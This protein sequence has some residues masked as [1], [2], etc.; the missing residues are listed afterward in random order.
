MKIL[1]ANPPCILPL[2]EG[3]ELSFVRAGSRWPFSDKKER[4]KPLN[5]IPFPF[6]L[7][8]LAALLQKDGHDVQV[9]DAVAL[10]ED[11]G[12]FLT[13]I[14]GLDPD[15]L[16]FET[17]TPT[18]DYDLELTRK[19]RGISRARIALAGAHA[20]TFAEEILAASAQIDFVFRNEYEISF[21]SMIS[22][23][24]EGRGLED[25]K[26][27]SLR[28]GDGSAF[29]LP[30]AEPVNL[31]ELDPPARELFPCND[32]PNLSIYWDGFCQFRPA[33]QMH[34]SRGCP[35]RCNFCVWN[36]VMY[37]EGRY[38]MFDAARVVDEM[39][40]MAGKYGAREIYFDD[41]TFTGNKKHV[42]EIT[43]EIIRRDLRIP[44]SCMGDAMVTDTEMISMM[45]KSGCVG[46]KFGVESGN[47]QILKNI[48]KP[49]KFDKIK[50]VA[51]ACSGH[52][53]KTH[54]TFTFGLFGETR[55]TM[56]E[57]LEFAKELDV[58]SVQFSITT[59]FPGTRY[60]SQCEA[61]NTITTRE[62]RKYDGSRSAVVDFE[63]LSHE[64]VEEFCRT[65]TA[66][67]LRHKLKDPG[68]V[69]RQIYLLNRLRK[70][71]GNKL[72][73]EKILRALRTAI[74]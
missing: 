40:M 53:I 59:P 26:G 5:Y 32:K 7:A 51:K 24:S 33:V 3:M 57:T 62:W 56:E 19:I 49:V 30:S 13:H 43:R 65:A 2:G 42:L 39:E 71:Q 44:W 14:R 45:A 10:N 8:Y 31:A 72:F 64:E 46:M 67:W 47:K 12:G 17:T 15:I 21:R 4:N 41:D 66:K 34:A 36:Q 54:A 28:R 70:G 18:I 9:V 68:W 74:Q 61:Q 69:L 22:A 27:F 50:M 73:T 6:Y 16:L 23:L 48:K 29:S 11:E 58:D 37:G 20:T 1:L 35:F 25:L 38:R 63:G 52:K 55:D 60:F